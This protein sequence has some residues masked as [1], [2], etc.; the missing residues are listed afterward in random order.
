LLQ[1]ICN[2]SPLQYLYQIGRLPL[3]SEL[4]GSITIP[5]EVAAEI[6]AGHESGVVLPDIAEIL[7]LNVRAP[8]GPLVENAA[9]RLGSGELAAITL[10]KELSDSLVV[11]DDHAARLCAARLGLRVTGV[12][13]VLLEAKRNGHI[14]SVTPILSDLRRAN[15]YLRGEVAEEFLRK[16]GEAT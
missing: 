5:V 1:V 7:W 10:A 6:Q 14:E 11:L 15:F 13:G 12:L 16:A 9:L 4:Y 2:T 3:L 8:N